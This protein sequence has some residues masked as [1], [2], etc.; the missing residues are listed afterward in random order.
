L[1]TV[2]RRWRR[3]QEHLSVARVTR[4][5]ELSIF[6][7]ALWFMLT[8]S[9]VAFL[10]RI[11]SR[12]DWAVLI[13]LLAALAFLHWLAKRQLLPRIERYFS[14]VA[15]DERRILFDLGQEARTVAS[16]GE[17]YESIAR[18]IAASLEAGDVSIFVREEASGDYV[19]RV[20]TS[21]PGRSASGEADRAEPIETGDEL[22]LQRDGFV[23][24]RLDGLSSP[25]VIAPTE[26]ETWTRALSGAAPG[27]RAARAKERETLKRIDSHLLVQVKTKDQLI[28]ILSLGL[29]RG[30]FRYTESDKE[31]LMSV[32]AQLALVI[33]NSRLAER[34]VAE[35]RLRR[36]LA[37]AWEVQR[38]LLPAEAPESV[39]VDLAGFCEPAGG[40]GGDYY[41]FIVLDNQQLGIAIA[42]V[43]GKGMPAALLM[44]TMQ[45]TLRSLAVRSGAHP[46]V[47]GS[48]PGMVTTL[49]RLLFDST[50]G[51][52]YVTFFYAQFDPD[53]LRLTY[54][55][56]GHNP[57]F[58]MRAS[59][60]NDFQ[61]LSAGGLIVGV[62]EHC[63]Y[64]Q[65]TIQME[66][67]D[68]LFAFTDGLTEALDIGGEEFGEARVKETLAAHVRLSVSEIR[69][70]IELRVKQ[71]CAGAPQYDDMTFVV[72]KVK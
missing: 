39:A 25:L 53:T 72:M 40:V 11:G 13:A 71:W 67:G 28:G 41:D 34:M 1:K 62:F 63:S 17:L 35:E 31:V 51:S 9:R 26:F 54:V 32:A 65:E 48:L 58:L 42:D 7:S 66:S 61:H 69:A 38:R 36:E 60:T 6:V 10:D 22:K 2:R 8:G 64:E 29:R 15:Y 57:P 70:G 56:A 45:A 68:V 27:L 21:Q 16:V 24:R 23:V 43:A 49:N 50:R 14:P 55:N 44:S 18:R 30:Q 4:I 33:E 37:M 5:V 47:N 19:C 12:G 52:N 46:H 20:S 59:Q 3:W